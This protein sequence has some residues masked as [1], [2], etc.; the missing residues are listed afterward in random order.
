[1]MRMNKK[2]NS[3]EVATTRRLDTVIRVVVGLLAVVAVLIILMIL[4]V[5]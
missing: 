4:G 2:G 1:M 3:G 5:I